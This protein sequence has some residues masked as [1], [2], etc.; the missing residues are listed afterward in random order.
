MQLLRA[1]PR[2]AE[3]KVQIFPN[4]TEHHRTQKVKTRTSKRNMDRKH[5]FCSSLVVPTKAFSSKR[6][7]SEIFDPARC[8]GHMS[9][10]PKRDDPG[11]K[12]ADLFLESKGSTA[13]ASAD[14]RTVDRSNGTRDW[15]WDRW[16]PWCQIQVQLSDE[17][18]K[19]WHHKRTKTTKLGKNPFLETIRN[20]FI[21]MLMDVAWC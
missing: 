18:K 10:P 1:E 2:S 7:R 19:K 14:G 15:T 13:S 11:L 8:S 21:V 6:T 5:L 20:L 3:S 17:R 12:L 16:K 9:V 4:L